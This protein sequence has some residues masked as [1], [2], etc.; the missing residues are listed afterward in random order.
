MLQR[1]ISP[2][3]WQHPCPPAPY[4]TSP[5]P[6]RHAAGGPQQLFRACSL[7]STELGKRAKK[8]TLS[9]PEYEFLTYE[10]DG[11]VVTITFDSGRSE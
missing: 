1:T 8:Q 11:P 5:G 3:G 6:A 9:T 4:S 2:A 7:G 10:Q